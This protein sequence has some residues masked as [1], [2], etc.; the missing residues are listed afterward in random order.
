MYNQERPDRANTSVSEKPVRILVSPESLIPKGTLYTKP[1]FRLPLVR[2]S[3]FSLTALLVTSIVS[4]SFVY[5]VFSFDVKNFGSPQT[6]SAVTAPQVQLLNPEGEVV[7]ELSYGSEPLLSQPDFFAQTK[8]SF[9]SNRVSFISADL[10]AMKLVYYQDGEVAF[11]APIAS[12]GKEGS[13]WETPAGLYSIEAKKESHFSSFGHVYQ[14]WSMVFQGNFFIHG[15]PEYADG[16]P[17]PAGYSGGCIRLATEDAAQLYELVGLDVPVLVYEQDFSGDDFKYQPK[18]PELTTDNYLVVDLQNNTILA[19]DHMDEVVPIASLTKLMTALI[20]AE[21]INLDKSVSISPERYVTTLIPR[22]EG[23]RS[24]SMYSLLQLLLVESSNEAAEVIAA[25]VGRDRFIG[26]M[27]DKAAA[28]GLNDTVFADPSGLEDGNVS[29]P[30]DMVQLLRYIYNNRSFVL[31]LTHNAD[32]ETAY[33]KGEFGKLENFNSMEGVE[34][35]IGGKVGETL[36]AGK[37]SASVHT[38]TV[39]GEERVVAIVLLGSSDRTGDVIAVH[40]Y[41]ANQFRD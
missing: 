33:K 20:A 29:T 30:A 8:S 9:I 11:E 7:R 14:P 2:V 16:T 27:N 32:L 3:T 19:G 6:A 22:L 4:A 31:E 34:N 36:A 15:W 40:K 41:L 25:V 17:V 24:V 21:Y 37:T 38:V 39:D 18:A 35:F 1:D 12:K 5:G 23:R 28:L 10:T 13:W 26:Y